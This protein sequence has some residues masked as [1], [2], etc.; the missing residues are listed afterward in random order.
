LEAARA[1]ATRRI[2]VTSS[3][4]VLGVT[5]GDELLDETRQAAFKA[6]DPRIEALIEAA[7]VTA[8]YTSRG[9]P[10]ITLLPALTLGPGEPPTSAC[11]RVLLE[12]L[13][14]APARRV[15]V[16]DGGVSLVDI[17]DVVE[18]HWRA[19]EHGRLG[20]RYVLGGENLSYRQL[21]QMLYE[22]AGLGRPGTTLSP[23]LLELGAW[24]REGRA[25]L[26]GSPPLVTRR[27]ARDYGSSR[28]WVTSA[29]AE[30]ELGYSH[31]SAREVLSRALSYY[32][33]KGFLPQEKARAIR[34]ER[35]APR[36]AGFV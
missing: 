31:R 9:M 21:L 35:R 33:E 13:K 14:L 28:V 26:S 29:K 4:A 19:L 27:L 6:P 34:L 22:L 16:S 36:A 20:E 10:I 8:E 15:P 11:A 1:R 5:K 24:L 32:L 23:A 18:G 7:R 12:Y 2:V 3:V 25:L 17:D 30:R